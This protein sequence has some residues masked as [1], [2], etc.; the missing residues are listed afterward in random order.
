MANPHT[1][2]EPG[3]VWR[4]AS[5]RGNRWRI[6]RI[7]NK[8]NPCGANKFAPHAWGIPLLRDGSEAKESEFGWLSDKGMP[9]PDWSDAW[10]LESEAPTKAVA[11]TASP[12]KDEESADLRFFRTSAHPNMCPKCGVSLPCSYHPE[13]VSC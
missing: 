1:K 10:S 8:A 2:V 3:Q 7:G 5:A 11:I 4:Q 9:H 12:A 6:T 13:V